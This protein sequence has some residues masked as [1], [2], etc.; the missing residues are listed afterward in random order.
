MPSYLQLLIASVIVC[1]YTSCSSVA[2]EFL[3]PSNVPSHIPCSTP[4][5]VPGAQV[6]PAQA[7]ESQSA[8]ARP[9]APDTGAPA[10]TIFPHSDTARWLV[11]GQA[12]IVFQGHPGFH[13]PYSGPNSLL[14]RGEYKVSL[15]GT[16]FTGFQ[17]LKNP[18]FSTDAIF[19]LE[20]ASGRGI[21]E[22]LGLAGFTNLDVVRNPTLGSKPYIARVQLHQVLGLTSKLVEGSRTPFSLATQVPERRFDLRA[23]KLTLPDFLDLNGPG[24]D[25]HLQ[26]LNWTADNNGAWDYAADTRGYTYGVLAEYDSPPWSARYAVAL[27]PTVANG[28]HLDWNLRRARGENYELELR[29]GPATFLGPKGLLRDRKGAIRLLGFV[30]HANMGIYRSANREALDERGA[31]APDTTPVITAH[32]PGTTVKYGIG[33]NFEQELPADVRLFG[34]FGWNEGQHESYAYTE[35]DQTFQLGGDMA[36]ARWGRPQD[37]FGVTGISNAIKR[38]HQATSPWAAWAFCSATVRCSTRAKTSWR[39]TTRLIT[40]AASS[41]PSTFK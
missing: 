35:V 12:N 32:T 26:F 28:I 13:S 38:D 37:K 4:S 2:Q 33:L 7:S 25:S 24:S 17:L 29:R 5:S 20:S 34:R 30:N 36:G 14:A 1:L 31:S 18:R 22:A 40:G 10:V 41:A 11:S 23:G 19:D 16:L 8:A 39:P 6:S 27:M 9:A 21:S 15:V 3:K